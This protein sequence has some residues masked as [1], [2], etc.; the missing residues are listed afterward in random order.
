[1]AN[2]T[3]SSKDGVC[4]ITLPSNVSNIVLQ[5]KT[6]GT[7]QWT[8]YCVWTGKWS[9]SEPTATPHHHPL[10]EWYAHQ[11]TL[12]IVSN[13]FKLIN[14]TTKHGTITTGTNP[15]T[16]NMTSMELAFTHQKDPSKTIL[17]DKLNI[18]TDNVND[19]LT[20]ITIMAEDGGDQNYL[21]FQ[22][23]ITITD[24]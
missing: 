12:D 4:T 8:N 24:N 21:D 15:S 1:M 22:M 9:L 10:G 3:A 7:T 13:H 17:T 20:V 5:P 19:D 18:D 16:A 11:T 23:I 2:A 6:S 14:S